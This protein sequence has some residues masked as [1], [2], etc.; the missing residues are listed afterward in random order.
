VA[1]HLFTDKD[2]FFEVVKTFEYAPC[3][4]D[5]VVT[6]DLHSGYE[7]HQ[8]DGTWFVNPGAVA[9]QTAPEINR[10]PKYAIIDV[11][12]PSECKVRE[13][14]IEC[15]IRGDDVFIET[16]AEVARKNDGFDPTKFIDNIEKFEAESVDVHQ[17]VQNVGKSEGVD[18]KVLSYLNEKSAEKV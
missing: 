11:L 5:L 12:G 4:Y 15:A 2:Y 18:D 9:R 8:V 3:P 14:V 7:P 10:I 16:I 13:V 17:L 1:H 6:G